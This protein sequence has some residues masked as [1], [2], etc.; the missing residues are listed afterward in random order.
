MSA[1]QRRIVLAFLNAIRKGDEVLLRDVL[2]ECALF[3]VDPAPVVLLVLGLLPSGRDW[4]PASGS[5]I[6]LASA[7]MRE[8]VGYFC[9]VTGALVEPR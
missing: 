5:R 6:D 8:A 1:E 3:E 7:A 2:A 9:A 4:V